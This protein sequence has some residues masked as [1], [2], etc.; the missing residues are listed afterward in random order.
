MDK[1]DGNVDLE[2]ILDMWDIDSKIDPLHLDEAA[3][4]ISKLHS[5][6]LRILSTTRLKAKK[7]EKEYNKLKLIKKRYFKGELNGTDTLKT[8][9]WEPFQLQLVKSEIDDLLEGDTDLINILLKKAYID[10]IVLAS[11]EIMKD[12]N[13]RGFNIKNSIEFRKLSNFGG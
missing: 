5:K 1:K 8:L 6:Y 7:I 4:K 12:L 3:E 2:Q 10:E 13:A 9:S 11:S